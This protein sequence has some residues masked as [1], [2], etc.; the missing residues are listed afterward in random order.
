MFRHR[1]LEASCSDDSSTVLGVSRRKA[2]ILGTG[3][4]PRQDY[5]AVLKINMDFAACGVAM[6]GWLLADQIT[7][8]ATKFQTLGRETYPASSVALETVTMVSDIPG[9]QKDM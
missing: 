4:L 8:E 7:D 1:L 6:L 5:Y 3:W 9:N 2:S